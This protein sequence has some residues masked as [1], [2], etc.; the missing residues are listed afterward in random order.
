MMAKGN[1]SAQLGTYSTQAVV[2]D[3]NLFILYLVGLFNIGEIE[4]FEKS[5]HYGEKQFNLLIKVLAS[6]KKIIITQPILTEATNHLDKLNRKYNTVFYRSILDSLLKFDDTSNNTFDILNGTA[7]FELGFAD[8]SLEILS[9]Q[10]VVLTDDTDL[11]GHII[12]KSGKA[13]FWKHLDPRNY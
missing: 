8:S 1:V 3:S 2:V 6:Y 4:L 10:Y 5:K 11:Y 12:S 9:Q 7:F 13:I